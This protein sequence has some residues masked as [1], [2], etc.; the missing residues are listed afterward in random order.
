MVV[1]RPLTWADKQRVRSWMA[2]REMAALMG[3]DLG[4]WD[5]PP[6]LPERMAMAIDAADGRFIGYLALRDVS[7]RQREA[8]LH[9]CIGEKDFWGRG[10]GADALRTYLRYIFSSTCLHRVYLR[11][12]ADNR[13]AVRCY[14]KCGFRP[15]G[16]L[17]AGTRQWRGFRD[18]LLMEVADRRPAGYNAGKWP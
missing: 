15:R 17:R 14:Q 8:E 10:M 16:I 18:L 4:P 1:L 5:S 12:Y 3:T 2:D 13:R 6:L 11:V 9:I 7:W